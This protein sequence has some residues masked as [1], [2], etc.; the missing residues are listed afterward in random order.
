MC[1]AVDLVCSGESICVV[2]WSSGCVYVILYVLEGRLL[3]DIFICHCCIEGARSSILLCSILAY[4]TF[5][6][7]LILISQ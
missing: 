5:S 3:A 6:L 2:I 4:G 7:L 1:D